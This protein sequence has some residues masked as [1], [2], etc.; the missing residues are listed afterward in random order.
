M[1]AKFAIVYEVSRGRDVRL[2]TD[3]LENALVTARFLSANS[4]IREATLFQ[5]LCQEHSARPRHIFLCQ[6]RH[7][8]LQKV[9][10]EAEQMMGPAKLL[11]DGPL[12]NA[13]AS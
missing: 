12:G 9:G 2:L 10:S 5:L 3:T 7:S 4:D 11:A 13:Q 1:T 8:R 6:F